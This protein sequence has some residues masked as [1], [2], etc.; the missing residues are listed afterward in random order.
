[1]AEP[2]QMLFDPATAKSLIDC[3]AGIETMQ[4]LVDSLKWHTPDA[5][6]WGW[7]EQYAQL[8]PPAARP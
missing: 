3:P 1:M 4:W 8:G 6:S 7:P 5:L 2:N